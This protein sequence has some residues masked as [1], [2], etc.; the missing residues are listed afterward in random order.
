M[1]FWITVILLKWNYS[2]VNSTIKEYKLRE[3]EEKKEEE[4]EKKQQPYVVN[5][6]N[7]K[8]GLTI[9]LSKGTSVCIFTY[10]ATKA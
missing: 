7:W 9:F 6:K 10:K 3:R 4:K 1:D 2:L 8:M 5:F